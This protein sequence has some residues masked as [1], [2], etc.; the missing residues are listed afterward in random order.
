VGYILSQYVKKLVE[1]YQA[2]RDTRLRD[3]II[4]HPELF[5]EPG[6]AYSLFLKRHK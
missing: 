6:E 2:E 1:N 5:P 4:R 3:Y